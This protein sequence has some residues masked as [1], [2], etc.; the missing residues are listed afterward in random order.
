M[1]NFD[2]F[3]EFLDSKEFGIWKYGNMEIRPG[4]MSLKHLQNSFEEICNQFYLVIRM[5]KVIESIQ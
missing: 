2:N 1:Q 5:T 3:I 4:Y